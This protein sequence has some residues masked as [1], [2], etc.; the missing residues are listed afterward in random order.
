ME[1]VTMEREVA[2]A[3]SYT[4]RAISALCCC[5]RFYL[6]LLDPPLLI[7]MSHYTWHNVTKSSRVTTNPG[8]SVGISS[9]LLGF[10]LVEREAF[11]F[12]LLFLSK[13][14]Q[15]SPHVKIDMKQQVTIWWSGLMRGAVSIALAYNQ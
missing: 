9:M 15:K 8:K 1:K 5:C 12:P 13:L 2:T 4:Y 14:L 11:V 6:A 7:V 3:A 10:I